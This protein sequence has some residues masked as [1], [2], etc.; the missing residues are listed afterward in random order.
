MEACWIQNGFT[1]EENMPARLHQRAVKIGV[2][3]ICV[4]RQVL[5]CSALGQIKIR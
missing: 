1:A 2:L 5:A 4:H 3:A